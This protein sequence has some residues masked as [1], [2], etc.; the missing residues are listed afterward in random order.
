MK[1][2][3]KKAIIITAIVMFLGLMLIL[4]G[5]FGDWFFG[6]FSKGFDY[7]HI[8]DYVGK[9]VEM[10][11]LVYYSN[12]DLKEKDITTQFVGNA[13]TGEGA[14]IVFDLSKL[15]AADKNVY[16][17]NYYMHVK[18][19]GRLRTM[20]D[21]E[22]K[23]VEESLYRL[24]DPIFLEMK[25]ERNQDMTLEEFNESLI[26]AYRPYCIEV[27]SVG[28]FNWTPFIPAGIIVLIISLVLEI[29]FVFKLK[30]RVVLPV[31]YGLMI[32]I[33]SIMFF[34]H[35]RT[36]T[37]VKKVC[38]GLYTMENIECTDTQAMLDS[39]SETVTDLLDWILGKH[40]YG[41]KVNFNEENF[42]I[43]C[44]AFASKTPEGDHLFG[45]NFDYTE[46][47]IVLVHSHPKGAYESIGIADLGVLGVGQ[48]YTIDPDSLQGK[49]YMVITP[50][51]VTD[52]MNEMGVSAG[53]LELA[54]D[55][56]HQDNG[57]PDL[58]VYC[59]VRG[60][61]D[62]CA[63]VDEALEF[64]SSYDIQSDLTATYHLFIT[65]KTG[66][67]VVVEWLDNEMV[68]T[69]KPCVTNSVV[70]PG[71]YFDFGEPDERL[72]TIESCLGK[73]MIANETEA[74]AILE[75]VSSKRITEWSCVY[76]LEKFK[77]N[78]CIDADYSKVYTIS[79][80]D[81]RQ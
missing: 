50:Y 24:Y 53:I 16:Y 37:S 20:D 59:A 30:K 43:G 80:K 15:S 70:A 51:L 65:D 52:G 73:D 75:K 22:F 18:I 23:E 13:N 5:F 3:N 35:I 21:A 42:R 39:G 79:A 78:I 81:F 47:D 45:R 46:T 1:T 61:L 57:K 72:G 44:A 54:I 64:L 60:I 36:M 67:Y 14:Y 68:V 69:E 41:L 2:R 10:E 7:N 29:C 33:P 17:A 56:T 31:A 71:I 62:K 38:D 58:L 26:S 66:R 19:Q 63:S 8:D 55:E 9:D 40:F 32:I 4:T 34:D 12:I 11:L 28:S 76:N 27:T 48:T 25:E 77:V 49:L 74:M 6:L